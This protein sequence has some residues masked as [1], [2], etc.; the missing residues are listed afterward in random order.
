MNNI[1]N[2]KENLMK[3]DEYIKEIEQK[4]EELA[5]ENLRKRMF[6]NKLKII[7]NEE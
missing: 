2:I 7:N 6:V 5:Q 3:L 4:K 1:D